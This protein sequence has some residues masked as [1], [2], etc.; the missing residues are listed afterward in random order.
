MWSPVTVLWHDIDPTRNFSAR[1]LVVSGFQVLL[2]RNQIRDLAKTVIVTETRVGI[3]L[4]PWVAPGSEMR[5]SNFAYGADPIGGA[6][7]SGARERRP[8]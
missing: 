1:C 6:R 8:R 4:H 3:A 5:R 2:I 7:R